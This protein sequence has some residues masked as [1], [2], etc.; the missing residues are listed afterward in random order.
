MKNLLMLYALL[1]VPMAL[2]SQQTLVPIWETN[3]YQKGSEKGAAILDGTTDASGN[4]VV[5]GVVSKLDGE[6][7]FIAN[8]DSSGKLNWELNISLDDGIKG[9]LMR[10]KVDG[11]GNVY[12]IGTQADAMSSQLPFAVKVD[13]NGT[14]QWMKTFANNFSAGQE[15][16]DVALTDKENPVFAYKIRKENMTSGEVVIEEMDGSGISVWRNARS[17]MAPSG[18]GVQ[19]KEIA[20]DGDGN[21]VGAGQVVNEIGDHFYALKISSLGKTLWDKEY[22]Q[23]SYHIRINKMK[24]DNQGNVIA[25]GEGSDIFSPKLLLVKVLSDST[26][27]WKEILE[28]NEEFAGYDLL[29]DGSDIYVLGSGAGAFAD[30]TVKVIK[31]NGAGAK[32]WEAKYA[33]GAAREMVFDGNSNIQVGAINKSTPAKYVSLEISSS[34]VVTSHN[35]GSANRDNFIFVTISLGGKS[36]CL[37]TGG[38]FQFRPDGDATLLRSNNGSKAWEVTRKANY[39]SDYEP[40]LMTTDSNDIIYVAGSNRDTTDK[41]RFYIDKLDGSGHIDWSYSYSDPSSNLRIFSLLGIDGD[42]NAYGILQSDNF[43][44]YVPK[45]V[46]VDK[47]GAE[48]F[49]IDYDYDGKKQLVIN[50]MLVESNGDFILI[51]KASNKLVITKMDKDGKVIWAKD[52]TVSKFSFQAQKVIRDGEGGYIIAGESYAIYYSDIYYLRINSSGKWQWMHQMML[53][54]S[55]TDEEYVK[56]MTRTTTGKYVLL[57]SDKPPGNNP[58]PVALWFDN[59]GNTLMIDSFTSYPQLNQPI[60]V[61]L[62]IAN[63]D[64]LFISASSDK[65]AY[66]TVANENGIKNVRKIDAS[67]LDVGLSHTEF[68]E[69]FEVKPDLY[70]T[71]GKGDSYTG[72]EVLV[73]INDTGQSIKELSY[74]PFNYYP[75]ENGDVVDLKVNDYSTAH[76]ITGRYKLGVVVVG[77]KEFTKSNNPVTFFPNPANSEATLKFNSTKPG[78]YTIQILDFAGQI[79]RTWNGNSINGINQV[80]IKNLELVPTGIY[81]LNFTSSTDHWTN[82]IMIYR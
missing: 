66:L 49:A 22:T 51:G 63:G 64:V 73:N 47:M 79:L 82:K 32:Q 40:G 26:F 2:M 14:Q 42:D 62:P 58:K 52:T 27:G 53:P 71:V 10:L 81:L 29:T 9:K 61:A 15:G 77:I 24:L 5:C 30:D 16:I 44:P 37:G 1:F 70:L 18:G 36:I 21:I 43:Y 12:A 11:S 35:L 33:D 74:E 48:Q 3:M 7:P 19:L 65:N 8:Y 56:Y 31:Y 41:Y 13:N 60:T 59:D 68:Y 76:G 80:S 25:T 50:D 17:T 45:I 39:F 54:K 6:V 57:G 23:V 38:G 67:S 4:I 46:K 72:V 69:L 28:P 20:I 75:M 55:S 78:S 34:G